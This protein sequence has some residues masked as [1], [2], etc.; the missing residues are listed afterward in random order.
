MSFTA[1]SYVI[2]DTRLTLSPEF[3]IINR[4]RAQTT[5]EDIV[6]SHKRVEYN[7]F[8]ELKGTMPILV[9]I[10]LVQP[11]LGGEWS[12]GHLPTAEMVFGHHEDWDPISIA[13]S[14]NEHE[15]IRVSDRHYLVCGDE[16]KGE[17]RGLSVDYSH[18]LTRNLSLQ[19]ATVG[20]DCQVSGGPIFLCAFTDTNGIEE[21]VILHD[22]MVRTI[23]FTDTVPHNPDLDA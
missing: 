23:G 21:H 16:H 4:L 15:W 22:T 8:L 11:R 13:T 14:I 6:F 12:I 17:K 1:T 2:P 19:Q 9:R 7:G 10:C 5:W 20:G 18:R 3:F